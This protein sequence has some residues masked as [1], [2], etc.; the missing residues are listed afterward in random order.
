MAEDNPAP[1]GEDDPVSEEENPDA[2]LLKGAD[3]PNAVSK[4][5]KAERDAA[6]EAKQ[7][8]D[9][10]AA[11]VKKFEDEGKSKQQRLEDRATAAEAEK[12]TA[13]AKLL[14]FEVAAAKGLPL[15][16][17]SRLSGATQGELEADADELLKEIVPTQP[18]FDGGARKPANGSDMNALIRQAAGR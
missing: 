7:R 4:A 8:A 15:K 11:Q 9:Q 10:L 6:R 3:N 5:L 13:E 12:G 1:E 2:E 18:G 16:W 14:R 17:A